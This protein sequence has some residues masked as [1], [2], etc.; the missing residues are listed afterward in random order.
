MNDAYAPAERMVAL[1]KAGT[2]PSNIAQDAALG[3]LS[4]PLA[5]RIC[6]L[7]Y[8]AR[9]GGALA[10]QAS[11][12][13]SRVQPELLIDLA[14]HPAAPDYLRAYV[15]SRQESPLGEEPDW[16]EISP[17]EKAFLDLARSETDPFTL[18]DADPEEV[19]E[20]NTLLDAPAPGKPTTRTDSPLSRIAKMSVPQRVQCALRGSRDERL[21]LIRDSN[22]VVQRAVLGSPRLT[23]NDVEL[24]SNMRNVSDE[25]LRGIAASRKFMASMVIIRNLVNNPRTPLDVALPL[26]KHLFQNDLR[27]LS[28]NKNVNELLRRMAVKTLQEKLTQ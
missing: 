15:A 17:E 3:R 12:T 2:V 18:V 7:A 16:A 24:I 9:D 20:L 25:V 27:I 14:A 8:L 22:K 13:L 4:L 1:L 21:L 5:S 26:V 10:A 23:T 11:R 6:V 28:S 19:R